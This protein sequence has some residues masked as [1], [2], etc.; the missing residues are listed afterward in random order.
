VSD[1]SEARGNTLTAREVLARGARQL[2]DSLRDQPPVQARLQATVGVV[3]TGLG[4]Y[5]DAQPLLERALQTQRRVVGEDD[6]ETL[7]TENNLAN[8]Y[9]HRGRYQEAEP[10]YLDIVQRRTRTLGSDHPDTLRAAFDLG[11]LYAMQERWKEFEPLARDTLARQ[12]RVLGNHHPDTLGS[13]GNLASVYYR[14]GRYADAEPL[15]ATR[16]PGRPTGCTMRTRRAR[17]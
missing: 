1:P 17:S 5:V 9:W 15:A 3:Y 13:L 11:S 7:A 4:L 8:V 16:T 10:L 14:Q 12:R 2:D 6:A